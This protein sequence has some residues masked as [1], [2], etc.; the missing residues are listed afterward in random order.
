MEVW[1]AEGFWMPQEGSTSGSGIKGFLDARGGGHK[2]F[3]VHGWVWMPCGGGGGV[4]GVSGCPA[5]G[6][7]GCRGCAGSGCPRFGVQSGCGCSGVGAPCSR[8]AGRGRPRPALSRRRGVPGEPRRTVPADPSC[9]AVPSPESAGRC[10]KLRV[11]VCCRGT[12]ES[13]WGWG[14]MYPKI[15][16]LHRSR[17]IPVPTGGYRS[18]GGD[19]T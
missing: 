3:R 8:S 17:G 5:V 7:V 11:T 16:G 18:L 9:P 6:E 2:G 19:S 14:G 15:R 10:L 4:Q 12:S 13:G 1:G